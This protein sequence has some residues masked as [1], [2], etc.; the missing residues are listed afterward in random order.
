MKICGKLK[1]KEVLISID[2][3]STHNLISS[4][5]VNELKIPSEMIPQF[6]VQISNGEII[7]CASVWKRIS[8]NLPGLTISEDYY[9]FS[10]KGADLVL[11]IK[12]LASLNTVQANWSQLFLIFQINGK[13]YKLQG[14][15]RSEP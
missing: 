2:S 13:R 7:Q 15:P 14:V 11:S 1:D 12:W 3:G 6:G 9:S 10:I 5:L 4:T 8:V